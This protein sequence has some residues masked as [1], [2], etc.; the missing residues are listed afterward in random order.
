RGCLLKSTAPSAAVPLASAPPTNRRE[1]LTTSPR[2]LRHRKAPGRRRRRRTDGT[3]L[4]RAAQPGSTRIRL[5]PNLDASKPAGG[6]LRRV[7]RLAGAAEPSRAREAT[8]IAFASGKGGTGKSFMATNTAICL[9]RAG[10][11]V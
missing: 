9:H 10:R 2:S 6:F 8:V 3:A 11:R 7:F 4:R 1:L 5:E